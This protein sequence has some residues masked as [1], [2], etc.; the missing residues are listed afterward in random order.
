MAGPVL[1]RIV[2]MTDAPVL[3]IGG[4]FS[5]TLL[6]INLVRLGGRVILIERDE[7]ALAKGL[8]FGT[9]H[10]EHLLNVRASNMSAFPDDTKHFLR[11]MGFSTLD[12]ANRFVP[13]LAYGQYLHALLV[14]SLA[15]AGNR[16]TIRPGTAVDLHEQADGV[17]L[18][19]QDGAQIVGSAAVLALGN[20]PPRLPGVLSGL[21]ARLAVNDPWATDALA[22]LANDAPVLLV[23]TGLTAVDVILSLTRQGHYGPVLSLSRRGLHPRSHLPVG[24]DLGVVPIPPERGTALIR[25]TRNRAK[26]VGWWQ[27]V[28]ELRPHTRTLWQAHSARSQAAFLRHL[29]PYWDVHRHRLAPAIAQQLAAQEATGRLNFAG[30]RI[31]SAQ[32][33]DGEVAVAWRPRGTDGRQVFHAARVINCTGPEGDIAE[34]RQPL[35][36]TLLERGT[37]R[38]DAH[39]LGLDVDPQWRVLDRA[40][41]AARRVFAAGPLT[42]GAAWEIIAV[43]DIRHQVWELART[44]AGKDTVVRRTGSGED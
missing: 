26:A 30:G 2:V 14:K 33:N 16:L 25:A 5:G 39:R 28:D 35:L 20:F 18:T 27:A 13:R 34:V 6:A 23:G 9:R 42:K 11:W 44:L 43:P 22:G 1:Q 3:I 36:S 41:A 29:R 17:V 21:P 4:G 19:L 10:S 12:Q 15:A 8:A 40:G 37:L 31:V 24:P 32:A 7:A 38:A